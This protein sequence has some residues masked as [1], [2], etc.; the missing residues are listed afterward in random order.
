MGQKYLA[1]GKS[2]S[3]RLW[4][5][6]PGKPRPATERAYETVGYVIKGRAKLHLGDQVI[7]LEPGNP[8]VVP[9]GESHFYELVE[10]FEAIEATHPPAEIHDR[11][12]DP[13]K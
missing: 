10:H 1:T 7:T 6:K 2:I 12:H 9:K 11:D 13:K 3:M 8:W 4:N 5:E